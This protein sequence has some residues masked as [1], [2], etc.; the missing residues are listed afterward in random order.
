MEFRIEKAALSDAEAIAAVIQT[1]YDTLEQKE[2]YVPDDADYIRDLLAPPQTYDETGN[3][4][5]QASVFSG[6]SAGIR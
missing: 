5:P 2:W 4:V 6:T 1:C 3:P